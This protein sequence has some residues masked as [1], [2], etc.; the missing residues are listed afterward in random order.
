MFIYGAREG[1]MKVCGND[2]SPQKQRNFEFLTRGGMGGWM[3]EV[4][5]K[6]GNPENV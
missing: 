1:E 6:K 3:P 2:E 5:L 4:F